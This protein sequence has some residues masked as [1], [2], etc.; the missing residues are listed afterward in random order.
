MVKILIP[1]RC[2]T[3]ADAVKHTAVGGFDY[4]QQQYRQP[5][6]NPYY[7][8]L[9]YDDGGYGGPLVPYTAGYVQP[10]YGGYPYGGYPDVIGFRNPLSGPYPTRQAPPYP[11]PG[12][13]P[14]WPPVPHPFYHVQGTY[15]PPP[16]YTNTTTITTEANAPV[17]EG[18]KKNEQLS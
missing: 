5:A 3:V 13:Q 10:S 9:P 17:T 7:D 1:K 12:A 14:L 4:L 2:P 11:S 8:P 6:Y 16:L 18:P 15:Y